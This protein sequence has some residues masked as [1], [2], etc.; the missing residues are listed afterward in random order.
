MIAMDPDYY[1]DEY[2]ILDID[3]KNVCD[4]L[5]KMGAVK[6]FDDKRT[7]TSFENSD[8]SLGRNGKHL[9]VVEEGKVKISFSQPFSE[10]KREEIKFK[11]TRVKE[12]FDFLNRLGFDPVAKSVSKRISYELNGAD[13]DI[14]IFPE[15]PPFLEIDLG[16][17]GLVLETILRQLGLRGN[18]QIKAGTTEI[19]KIYG[20][21]YFEMFKIK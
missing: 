7:T 2:K 9:K 11:T 4:L 17:S 5:E 20:K 13:F 18:I 3:V 6:V 21:D 12:V 8:K 14:D 19:Y 15:I 1:E 10:G 16:D